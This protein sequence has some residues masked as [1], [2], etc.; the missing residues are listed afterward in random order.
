MNSIIESRSP[1]FIA[2]MIATVEYLSQLLSEIYEDCCFM[3]L[4]LVG[5]YGSREQ[6]DDNHI[7]K[8]HCFLIEV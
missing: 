6:N 7:A 3:A 5:L 4:S 1:A 2:L 8:E